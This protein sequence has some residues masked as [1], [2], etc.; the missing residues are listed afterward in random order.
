MRAEHTGLDA[1]GPRH[2]VDLEHLVEA[3]ERDRDDC[4]G[5]GRVHAPHDR[6]AAPER[7]DHV[8][9]AAAPIDGRRELGFGRRVRDDVRRVRELECERASAVGEVGAVRVERALPRVSGAPSRERVGDRD[10]TR[11]Q[12]RVVELRD[13]LGHDRGARALGEPAMRARRAAAWWA[14]RSRGTRPRTI[15][16]TTRHRSWRE[17]PSDAALPLGE[18]RRRGCLA[19]LRL[20]GPPMRD[21]L[22]DELGKAVQLVRHP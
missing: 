10:A 18:R 19:S 14:P 5:L 13:G 9:V 17:S 7:H 16:G 2:L 3:V 15:G 8:A 22:H 4:I 20:Y 21:D 6:A 12:R 1:R 11:A